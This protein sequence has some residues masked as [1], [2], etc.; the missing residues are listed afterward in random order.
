MTHGGHKAADRIRI[1]LLSVSACARR[2]RRDQL[3]EITGP[4]VRAAR[5][6]LDIEL[7]HD[8]RSDHRADA[9]L[10]GAHA[11]ADVHRYQGDRGA[12][13]RRELERRPGGDAG[14]ALHDRL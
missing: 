1:V 12:L 3:F 10:H 7:H 8:T 13:A 11:A 5:V 6:R 9:V 4:D 2:A 14:K